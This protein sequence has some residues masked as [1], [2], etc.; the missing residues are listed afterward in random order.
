MGGNGLSETVLAVFLPFRKNGDQAGVE[1][2]KEIFR[3]CKIVVKMA[4]GQNKRR[5]DPASR[6]VRQE[7]GDSGGRRPM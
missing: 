6:T 2:N 7:A 4:R 1:L 5:C 3:R